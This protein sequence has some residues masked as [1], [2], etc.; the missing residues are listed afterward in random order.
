MKTYKNI[1]IEGQE[2]MSARDIY[3]ALKVKIAET[4][5]ELSPESV[6]IVADGMLT[7]DEDI[8]EINGD[9]YP[10]SLHPEEKPDQNVNALKA[11]ILQNNEIIEKYN[12]L[13]EEEIKEIEEDENFNT[14]YENSLNSI[15]PDSLSEEDA[16]M[17]RKWVIVNWD[18]LNGFDE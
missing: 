16:E 5:P 6:S 9:F 4:Y 10:D 17:H 11:Q 7:Y 18:E 13:T 15:D 14:I 3:E 1:T 8:L 12:S 2:K